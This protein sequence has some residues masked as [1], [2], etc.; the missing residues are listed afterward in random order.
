MDTTAIA[1]K[2]PG[3]GTECLS[4]ILLLQCRIPPMQAARGTLLTAEGDISDHSLLLLKGWIG[5]SQTLLLGDIRATFALNFGS[6]DR[7]EDAI[8]Q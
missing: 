7:P 3:H 6:T 1:P 8:P 2:I 5:L 4:E